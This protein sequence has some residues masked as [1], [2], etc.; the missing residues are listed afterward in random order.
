MKQ[1]TDDRISEMEKRL[2]ELEEKLQQ[3]MD[4]EGSLHKELGKRLVEVSEEAKSLRREMIQ[5]QEDQEKLFHD[6]ISKMESRLM[7]IL[8]EK[9]SL[10]KE[11]SE[12]KTDISATSQFLETQFIDLSDKTN[13]AIEKVE[14]EG[15]DNS[16]IIKVV[17]SVLCKGLNF[18]PYMKF[19]EEPCKYLAS[20]AA[21]LV[22]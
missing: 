10:H 20:K 11:I 15:T 17:V 16:A 2:G 8:V 13:S 5:K 19:L 9:G 21:H 6:K 4:Q 22:F 18:V 14:K 3:K 1:E 7:E 12:I